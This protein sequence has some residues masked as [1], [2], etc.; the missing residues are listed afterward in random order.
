[1]KQ[2]FKQY[3]FRS[4]T[5]KGLQ[6]REKD[7]TESKGKSRH[8]DTE[9]R[10]YKKLLLFFA[11]LLVGISVSFSAGAVSAGRDFYNTMTDSEGNLNLSNDPL[12]KA[13]VSMRNDCT[14]RCAC[15]ATNNPN[16][17][18]IQNMKDYTE[19]NAE[20]CWFC[21]IFDTL[22]SAVNGTVTSVFNTLGQS[23]LTLLGIGL[24]F[25][26]LFKVG[27]MLVQLQEVDVMQFLNDLFKPLGRGIIAMALL[28]G[29]TTQ[30]DHVFNMIATPIFE[31]STKMGVIVMDTALPNN[32]SY[33]QAGDGN[34]YVY[35]AGRCDNIDTTT[36]NGKAFTDGQR[37]LLTCWMKQISSSFI[38][39]I[40]IGGTLMDAGTEGMNFF[41]G[42][43]TMTIIGLVIWAC[44]YLIYLFFP[45]KIVD[46]FVRMAFVLTLMPLWIVLWVFPATV[47]Y[48]KKAWEMF[49]SSCITFIIISIMIS[50]AVI[51]MSNSI[52]ETD[53]N[54]LLQ[55]LR[56]GN[57]NNAKTWVLIG[58]GAFL[59]T[60]AFTAM[61]WTLLGTAG[62]LANT[63]VGGGGDLGIGSGMAG[64]T[65]RGAS[66]TWSAA[67]NTAK[68]GM[69]GVGALGGL[70]MAA[71]RRAGGGSG[72]RG[73]PSA[74]LGQ[75]SGGNSNSQ[76]SSQNN[77]N[78]FDSLTPEDKNI[79]SNS[80]NDTIS[81]IHNTFTNGSTFGGNNSIRSNMGLQSIL[82]NAN[83]PEKRAAL[84]RI[85]KSMDENATGY[86]SNRKPGQPDK[87]DID[88]LKEIHARE[89]LANNTAQQQISDAQDKQ[90]QSNETQDWK[91]SAQ[92]EAVQ[93][94]H[95]NPQ[96]MQAVQ[97]TQA[98]MA[99][100]Q[101][102]MASSSS[103][104][105]LQD[106]LKNH[107]WAYSGGNRE[108]YAQK[109]RNAAEYMMN[110]NK[111]GD[112]EKMIREVKNAL[113][114][115]LKHGD[116]A[117]LDTIVDSVIQK[118]GGNTSSLNDI[119]TNLTKK[120]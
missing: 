27:K 117:D 98:N 57:D 37:D 11:V 35:Q 38:V 113:S 112:S 52:P 51:L 43:F 111:W 91:Q 105:E 21:G 76:T 31:V 83:S 3:F 22:F 34:S 96:G 69:L 28:L 71:G 23:F 86:G 109:M 66:V 90:K 104:S 58:S 46:A 72:G 116:I 8:L 5:K 108:D 63:F 95:E 103:V 92:E 4:V 40:A 13:G 2:Y 88:A 9:V 79:V 68:V 100:I 62:T 19:E 49:L 30:S 89:M 59:N 75:Y 42:G 82:M 61:S 14:E 48:T 54:G 74:S 94:L 1:M 93:K 85:M 56:A 65:A 20:A 107:D 41:T 26:I 118:M 44:F 119:L 97:D 55:C 24:L 99:F 67:K 18:F 115:S 110:A 7:Y 60:I 87:K 106:K 6:N 70:A 10:M 25:I 78:A 73:K 120:E 16:S 29:V 36:S 84:E 81:S 47:G 17:L 33:I 77:N 80:V 32:V 39:G 101:E 45:F 50:L 102:Q 64:L 114:T 15:S 53:R 12:Y